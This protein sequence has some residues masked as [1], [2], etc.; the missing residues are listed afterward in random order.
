MHPEMGFNRCAA[1]VTGAAVTQEKQHCQTILDQNKHAALD[2]A[3]ELDTRMLASRSAV[4]DTKDA[5][6]H[7][8]A[9]AAEL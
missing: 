8:A 1:P 4:L 2:L 6:S 9:R 3:I 5:D 7:Q